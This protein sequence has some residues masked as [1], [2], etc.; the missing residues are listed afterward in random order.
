M[1]GIKSESSKNIFEWM[2]WLSNKWNNYEAFIDF[3]HGINPRE[4]AE[5]FLDL[6]KGELL[7]FLESLDKED[8][9]ALDQMQKLTESESYVLKMINNQI[10]FKD[11]VRYV[12]FKRKE[13]KPDI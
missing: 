6:N 13:N 5:N 11:K 1:N 10:H 7:R 2:T 3:E 12:N 9:D 8:L 4:V